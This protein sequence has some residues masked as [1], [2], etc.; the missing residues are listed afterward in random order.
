MFGVFL[1]LTYY[2]QQTLGYSPLKTGLAFVPMTAAL[3]ITS[4]VTSTRVLPR[5]GPRPLFAAGMALA[6]VGLV[7]L[8]Q[9]GVH[10]SYATHVLPGL[11]LAGAGIGFVFPPAT[12]IATLGVNPADAGAASA[13]ANTAPQVG[14]SIGTALLSTLAASATSS[15]LTGTHASANLV[16]RAAVHG[17]TTAFWWSA[18]IFAAGALIT[19]L[20]VRGKIRDPAP[21]TQ[22][23]AQPLGAV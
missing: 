10:A 14:G 16:A 23:N 2:L 8:A 11:I 15:Y 5:T 1:F 17:Y 3:V 21:A 7:L 22:P 18:G 13:M 19:A 6:A 9:L 4:A 12:N 20:L